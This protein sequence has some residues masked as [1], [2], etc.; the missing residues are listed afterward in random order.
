M[1]KF[2]INEKIKI[3]LGLN[4]NYIATDLRIINKKTKRDIDKKHS[5]YSLIFK[6]KNRTKKFT[7]KYLNK[8]EIDYF[9]RFL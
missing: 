2:N 8:S 9:N 1:Q 3:K 7:T 5:K 4:M 6:Q